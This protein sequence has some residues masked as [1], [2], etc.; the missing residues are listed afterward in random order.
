M[1]IYGPIISLLHLFHLFKHQKY[2][3]SD[4]PNLLATRLSQADYEF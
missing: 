4:V 3:L 2:G 1:N